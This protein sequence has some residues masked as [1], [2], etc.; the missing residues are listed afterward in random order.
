MLGNIN[1]AMMEGMLTSLQAM[2][3]GSLKQVRRTAHSTSPV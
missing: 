2:D 1:P 3:E